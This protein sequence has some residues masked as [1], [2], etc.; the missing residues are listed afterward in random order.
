M[1]EAVGQL[2]HEGSEAEQADDG[3]HGSGSGH[4]GESMALHVHTLRRPERMPK[5]RMSLLRQVA[6]FSR[7]QDGAMTRFGTTGPAQNGR[8]STAVRFQRSLPGTVALSVTAVPTDGTGVL[9]CWAQNVSPLGVSTHW[10]T[11]D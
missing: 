11:I 4:G 2:T 6:A 5:G 8:I 7:K 10:W 9:S 1:V 3:E